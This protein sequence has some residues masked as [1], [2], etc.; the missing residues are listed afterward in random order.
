[1]WLKFGP[2]KTR[3]GRSAVPPRA[4]SLFCQQYVARHVHCEFVS[5]GQTFNTEFYC[6][7]LRRSREDIRH[8]RPELC[9]DAMEIGWYIITTC[10]LTVWKK[11][12]VLAAPTRSSLS[13]PPLLTGYGCL[14][15]FPLPQK[16][17]QFEWFPFWYL[18]EIQRVLQI[19]MK[20]LSVSVPIVTARLPIKY[21]PMLVI[22]RSCC[23]GFDRNKSSLESF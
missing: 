22:A 23:T 4:C 18:G 21:W 6:N 17:V 14:W 20:N 11:G 15:C 2:R 8:T 1:M 19:H 12:K 9:R 3:R 7:V 13:L 5:Q 16:V 10:P